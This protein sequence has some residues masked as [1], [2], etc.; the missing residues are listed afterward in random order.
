MRRTCCHLPFQGACHEHRQEERFLERVF[1]TTFET[2]V[3]VCRSSFFQFFS[4]VASLQELLHEAGSVTLFEAFKCLLLLHLETASLPPVTIN[5][6][7]NP[8][9][10]SAGAA[11]LWEAILSHILGLHSSRVMKKCTP[12]KQRG[13]IAVIPGVGCRRACEVEFMA[14]LVY[15]VIIVNAC[16]RRL[17]SRVHGQDRKKRGFLGK[18]SKKGEGVRVS[19]VVGGFQGAP[20]APPLQEP[21]TGTASVCSSSKQWGRGPTGRFSTRACLG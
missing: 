20:G 12:S 19:G 6:K 14:I 8:F 1:E 5:H 13:L 15:F 7:T 17:G 21:P 11:Q 4:H 10:A 16:A 9:S 2:A 3:G 18:A